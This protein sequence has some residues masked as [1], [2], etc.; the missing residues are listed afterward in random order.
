[1]KTHLLKLS[2]KEFCATT[3]GTPSDRALCEAR[4]YAAGPATKARISA[5]PLSLNPTP[6]PGAAP[7]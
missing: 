7:K 6:N 5:L 3:I 1:M 4:A 2:P